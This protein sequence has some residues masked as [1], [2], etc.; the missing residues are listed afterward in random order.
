MYPQTHPS[1]FDQP[2]LV[3]AETLG[4]FTL[5]QSLATYSIMPP[6]KEETTASKENRYQASDFYDK[7]F[8]MTIEPVQPKQD[9]D[10]EPL[11]QP[12][13]IR[14]MPIQFFRNNTFQAFATNKILRGRF[15]ITSSD[16]LAFDVSL[17]GAGRSM[18]GSVFSEGIGLSHEDKRSYL[19]RIEEAND[20]I[21][22]EG[23]D[24]GSDARPGELLSLW[25]Q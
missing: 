6:E 5:E 17:F 18:P 16:K 19:G 23:S 14:A 25:K 2:L 20:R 24:L 9:P 15:R 8:I 12:V 7:S 22:V 3:N 4:P 1:F 13:D 10:A 11:N 21:Y